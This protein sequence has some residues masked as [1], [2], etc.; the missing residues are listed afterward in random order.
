MSNLQNRIARK[1]LMVLAAAAITFLG[2]ACDVGPPATPPS[3]HGG[4][5]QDQP[6]LID[7]LRAAGLTVN[8][9]ANIKQPFLSGSGNTVQIDGEMIQVFEYADE[10]A[11]KS[12]A[13]KIQPN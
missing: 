1:C 11:A 2:T 12:D 3:S 8:P 13:A 6:S 4:P 5:V 7:A 9:V 10:N